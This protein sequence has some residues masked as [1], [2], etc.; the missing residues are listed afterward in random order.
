LTTEVA[1]EKEYPSS[2]GY[3]TKDAAGGFIPSQFY[4]VV[5]HVGSID[6]PFGEKRQDYAGEW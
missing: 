5:G 1:H 2:E 4:G 3:G 6:N